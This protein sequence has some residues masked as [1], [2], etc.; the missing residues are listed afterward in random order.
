MVSLGGIWG[1]SVPQ[2][3]LSWEM[4]TNVAGAMGPPEEQSLQGLQD[5]RRF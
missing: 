1:V 3:G 2:G 4:L 5:P